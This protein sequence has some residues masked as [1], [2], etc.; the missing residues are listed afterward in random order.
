MLNSRD[1]FINYPNL[2]K[3]W[4]AKRKV[5]TGSSSAGFSDR[6]IS[7]WIDAGAEIIVICCGMQASEIYE[8]STKI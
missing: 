6:L 7:E 4:D 1:L 5:W 2:D 3:F 8:I